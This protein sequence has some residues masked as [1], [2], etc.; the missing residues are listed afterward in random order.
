MLLLAWYLSEELGI[1]A[2]AEADLMNMKT[3]EKL[4]A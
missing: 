1:Y 3:T 4:C 2:W